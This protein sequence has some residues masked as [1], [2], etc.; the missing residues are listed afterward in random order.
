MRIYFDENFSPHLVAGIRTIQDG[1]P[2]EDVVVASVADEFGRGAA[3]EVWIPG[4]AS[5]NG[6]AL[7]QDLNIHRVRAQWELC[8]ANKIGVFFFKPPGKSKAWSY[9]EIAKVV[10]RHWPEIK[11]LAASRSQPFGFA[12]ELNKAKFSGL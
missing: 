4:V 12:V 2:R 10:T 7:T 9:W 11:S 5:R 1:R 8:K 6:V 3:D